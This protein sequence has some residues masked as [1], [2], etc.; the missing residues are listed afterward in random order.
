M[1]A[2]GESLDTISSVMSDIDAALQGLPMEDIPVGDVDSLTDGS[3][4]DDS[5]RDQE[6]MSGHHGDAIQQYRRGGGLRDDSL[7]DSL[8]EGSI[9]PSPPS[10]ED[11]PKSRPQV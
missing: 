11:V 2:D 5:L 4:T 7:D 8:E 10:R 9:T 1:D 6:H 3:F